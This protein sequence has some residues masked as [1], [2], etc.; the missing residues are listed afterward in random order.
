MKELI[1][2]CVQFEEEDRADWNYIF[3]HPLVKEKVPRIDQLEQNLAYIV[4]TLRTE[5]HSANINIKSLF[6]KFKKNGQEELR[7]E[8]FCKMIVMLV[9]EDK[10]SSDDMKYT[11]RYFDK[12]DNGKVSLDEFMRALEKGGVLL[13]GTFERGFSLQVKKTISESQDDFEDGNEED[14]KEAAMT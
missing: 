3:N 14:A 5:I 9:G 8:S 6:A 12:D 4:S 11:F 1:L 7:Q 13:D 10:I 2:R